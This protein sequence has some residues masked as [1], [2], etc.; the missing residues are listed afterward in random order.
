MKGLNNNFGNTTQT[1][2]HLPTPITK[3]G[4]SN[5]KSDKTTVKYHWIRVQYKNFDGA[6]PI[7]SVKCLNKNLGHKIRASSQP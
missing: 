6:L 1:Q 4:L 7:P 3:G 2:S 5:G